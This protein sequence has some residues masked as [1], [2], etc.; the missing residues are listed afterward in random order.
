M[1]GSLFFRTFVHIQP[2]DNKPK[3]QQEQFI[4]MQNSGIF[5]GITTSQAYANTKLEYRH[6]CTYFNAFIT[7]LQS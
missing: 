4:I 3:N 5:S 2:N 7:E 6:V 1:Q